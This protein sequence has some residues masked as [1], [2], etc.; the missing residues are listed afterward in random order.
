MNQKNLSDVLRP[1][2]E[3]EISQLAP[4]SE[5]EIVEAFELGRRDRLKA[6]EK[7]DI[8]P[9]VFGIIFR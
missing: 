4:P 7:R 8:I 6:E 5:S 3:E 1:L 2:S 9:N